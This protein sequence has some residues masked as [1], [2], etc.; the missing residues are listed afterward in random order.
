MSAE[1]IFEIASD[2]R[3]V[4]EL[5]H[6]VEVV[7]VICYR[8]SPDQP[9]GALTRTFSSIAPTEAMAAYWCGRQ[10]GRWVKEQRLT[11]ARHTWKEA[12][13]GEDES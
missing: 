11:G 6:G 2:R 5:A 8:I 1:P 4:E 3:T 7:A 12:R 9:P 10:V 13:Y